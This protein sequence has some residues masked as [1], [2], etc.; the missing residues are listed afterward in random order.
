MLCMTNNSCILTF[1]K[2]DQH[3]RVD[4]K[5]GQ[6]FTS[7]SSSCHL[8]T[9]KNK[10][11]D[12]QLKIESKVTNGADIVLINV[13]MSGMVITERK[14]KTYKKKQ[15]YVIK[16]QRMGRDEER[17]GGG[18]NLSHIPMKIDVCVCV[19]VLKEKLATY[20]Y[21]LYTTKHFGRRNE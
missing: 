5:H 1:S 10:R 8:R 6:A 17:E 20:F 2:D 14:E 15:S 19:C 9:K 4:T 16:G 11:G 3:K 12:E 21:L 13:Q 7:S 18:R